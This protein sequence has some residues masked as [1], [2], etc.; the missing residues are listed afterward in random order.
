VVGGTQIP[1]PEHFATGVKI[2]VVALQEASPQLTLL[3]AC[4]QAPAPLQAPVLPQGGAAAHCPEGAVVP[5]AIAAQVPRLPA[6]LQALHV[7][8]GPVPQQIPSVQKPLIH[9]L[10]AVQVCPLGLSAQLLAV[11]VP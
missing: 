2:E 3:A 6:T 11:P 1:A 5:A 4:V 8:H 10:A 7:P 9:W